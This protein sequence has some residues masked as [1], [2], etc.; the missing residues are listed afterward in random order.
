[1][2]GASATYAFGTARRSGSGAGT[3]AASRTPV[4]DQHALELER[5]DPVVG[6]L[7]DVVGAPT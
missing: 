1:V 2:P 3:T 6:G 7:E 5:R 4:L